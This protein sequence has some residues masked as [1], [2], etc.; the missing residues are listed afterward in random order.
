[1]AWADGMLDPAEESLIRSIASDL[2]LTKRDYEGAKALFSRG[3]LAAAYSLLGVKP[4]AT[5]DQIKTSY[6]RL[7]R[8]YHPD[9]LAAKGL[10]EDF[11]KFATEKLQAINDAYSQI[12]KARGF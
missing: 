7:A 3:N 5:V 12:R 6:R 8:E 9:T 10:P 4:S 1:M 2:G 11:T